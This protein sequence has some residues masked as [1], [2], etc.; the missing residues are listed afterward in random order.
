MDVDFQTKVE[1]YEGKAAKCKEAALKAAE[2]AQRTMY[3]VLADYYGGLATD[4]RQAIEKR[5]AA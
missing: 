4:F 2:G 3:E 1:K 5:K